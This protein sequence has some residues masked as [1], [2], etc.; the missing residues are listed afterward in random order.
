MKKAAIALVV[1]VLVLLAVPVINFIAGPPPTVLAKVATDDPMFHKALAVVANSCT[2]CHTPETALPFYAGLPVAGPL[3]NKD[4]KEGMRRVNYLQEL[5]PG[6]GKPVSEVVLAKTE[7]VMTD[8]SMP[9]TRYVMLHWDARL[10]EQDR[11]DV[12]DWV[13]KVRKEHYATGTAAPRFADEMVQPLPRSSEQDPAKV[14]LGKRL[15]DDVRL[16][17]DNTISCASCHALDKGGTDRQQF[18]TGV[19][20]AKGGINA[21]TVYNSGLNFVQFWDG[22]AG[23][24]EDQADGPPNNPIEMASN[25]PEIFAKLAE[26]A[27]FMRQYLAVYPDSPQKEHV[28]EA[29][30]VFERT[31]LTPNSKFDKYLMGDDAALTEDEKKGYQTFKEFGCGTCHVGKLM[32]GQS[33]ERMGEQADYFGQRGNVQKPD[34]GRFNVTQKD[35]DRHKFKTPTLR[36]IVTT[37]PYLHEGS[38]SDLRAVVQLMA[39]YQVGRTIT[40]QQTG[41][42]VAFL[43]TLTGEYEGALLQ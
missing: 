2:N 12:M 32:G 8:K 4:I 3:I 21:P 13:H 6:D 31:L 7:Q 5:Q 15:Y 25:W 10:S 26:D 43:G 36:N 22:R 34:L 27:D 42:I 28:L 14:A 40:D 24:L 18:S 1:V 9:P 41:A 16:S 33:V 35:A 17:K 29:I 37:A 39:K 23:S 30:A 19:G 38:T 11:K 20:G